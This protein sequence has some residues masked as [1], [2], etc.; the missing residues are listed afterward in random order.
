MCFILFLSLFSLLLRVRGSIQFTI[1][2]SL[3][4]GALKLLFTIT[5]HEHVNKELRSNDA[6]HNVPL[7]VAILRSWVPTA[8]QRIDAN[9]L[10]ANMVA[11]MSQL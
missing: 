11:T 7:K 9:V 10:I 5:F 8:A 3:R 6:A 2:K 4:Y 1:V